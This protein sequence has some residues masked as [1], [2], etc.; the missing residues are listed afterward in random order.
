MV[1]GGDIVGKHDVMFIDD[2]EILTLTSEINNRSSFA[3]GAVI[4]AAYLSQQQ[5]GLYNM[6]DVLG[7]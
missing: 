1:R 4:A 7:L 6:F 3:N 2:G 5:P